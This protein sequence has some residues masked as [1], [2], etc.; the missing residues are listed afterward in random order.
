[1]T[2][3]FRCSADPE[4]MRRIQLFAAEDNYAD[5]HWLKIILEQLGAVYA[6]SVVTDGEKAV[7]FLLKRGEYEKAPDPDLIVLD[8]SLPRLTGIEVLRAIP[9]CDQLPIC[10]VTGSEAERGLFQREFGIKESAYV[11]KPLDD[12]KLLECFR[13]YD[14]LRPIAEELKRR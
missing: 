9:N 6:L 1:M 7:D 11:L 5:I 8:I 2:K 10:V 13:C 14:H 12:G 3:P 4:I